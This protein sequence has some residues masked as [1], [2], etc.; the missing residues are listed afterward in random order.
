MNKEEEAIRKALK[1]TP[2]T[3]CCDVDGCLAEYHGWA[4]RD[5][6]GKPIQSV[7]D[8]LKKEYDSGSRI[9]IFTCR[10]NN[11]DNTISVEGVL[12]LYNWLK[13]HKI[14][15][16]SI[17]TGVGKPYAHEYWDDKAVRKP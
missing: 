10:V 15:Y 11:L 3:I 13:E 6:I 2:R 16:H 12:S 5:T 17:W 7:V 1:D 4:G 9:I 8:A 14:G